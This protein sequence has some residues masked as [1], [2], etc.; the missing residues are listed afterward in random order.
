[1]V[2]MF[3]GKS[4]SAAQLATKRMQREGRPELRGCG[5]C[6]QKVAAEFRQF[7][8]ESRNFF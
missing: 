1:M 2:C 4:K 8:C 7:A 5:P 3:K 6:S